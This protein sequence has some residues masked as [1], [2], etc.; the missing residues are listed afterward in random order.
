MKFLL[1]K[2]FTKTHPATSLP[3]FTIIPYY[4][5][6]F[7]KLLQA[8]QAELVQEIIFYCPSLLPQKQSFKEEKKNTDCN[9]F[10]IAAL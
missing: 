6:A 3:S 10:N 2:T 4:R 8:G 9:L 1:Y 5:Q 7:R